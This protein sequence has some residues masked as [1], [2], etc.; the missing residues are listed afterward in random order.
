[1]K[2]PRP[3]SDPRAITRLRGR[4]R[5]LEHRI[6]APRFLPVVFDGIGAELVPGVAGDVAIH[7]DGTISRWRL[8]ADQPGD[9]QIDVWKSSYATFPPTVADTITGSDQ[10]TLSGADKSESTALTGWDI[11]VNDG[12]TLRFN[13]DSASTVTRVTLLLTLVA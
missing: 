2:P 11:D 6:I 12:D 3:R 7:F 9:I 13:I 4:A 1:V 8:L 10:P 5:K